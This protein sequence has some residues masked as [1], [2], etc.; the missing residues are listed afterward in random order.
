MKEGEPKPLVFPVRPA[1]GD[2]EPRPLDFSQ[3]TTDW[4]RAERPIKAMSEP[5]GLNFGPPPPPKPAADEPRGLPFSEQSAKLNNA[6]QPSPDALLA[7][8]RPARTPAAPQ[9]AI[10]GGDPRAPALIAK[11][12]A[13]DPKLA[14]HRLFRGRLELF[15][16]LRPAQWATWAEK[17]LAVLIAAAS[18]QADFARRL[19]LANAVKWANECEQAYKKPPGF[20]DRLAPK[21]EFYKERLNQARDV[22]VQVTDEVDALLADL[23]PRMENISLDALVLQVATTGVTDPSDQITSSRRL[24]TIVGGQQTAAMIL[25]GLE[26]IQTSAATQ[27]AAVSD[28]L[29]VTIPNWIM[30][31]SKA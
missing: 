15:L 18:Q 7:Q 24:Q 25:Q 23:K 20:L 16:D 28:L 6:K 10:I 8:L 11:A 22:L 29:T 30:A 12:Q 3:M 27:K 2:S 21:P 19:S 4:V 13:I 31:R 14:S 26:H 5:K 1:G 9:E 17:D